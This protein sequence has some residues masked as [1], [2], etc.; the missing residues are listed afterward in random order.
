QGIW[1]RQDNPVTLEEDAP[2]DTPNFLTLSPG[3][4]DPDV[5]Q[6]VSSGV[7]ALGTDLVTTAKEATGRVNLDFTL[8]PNDG[9]IHCYEGLTPSSDTVSH[10]IAL[11]AE[12][13]LTVEKQQTPC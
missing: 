12:D 5:A 6:L 9:T 8:V 11:S 2:N 4:V 13:V 3:V 7:A 10:L 1:V